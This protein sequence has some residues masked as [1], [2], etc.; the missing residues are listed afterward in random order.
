MPNNA[1][2]KLIPMTTFVIDYYS[3]EGYADLQTLKLMINYAQFLKKDLQLGMFV[4]VDQSGEPLKEPKN[5][6]SWKSIKHNTIESEDEN[7]A[8][9]EYNIY[10]KAAKKCLFEGFEVAYNG[11]SVVRIVAKYNQSIELS[12]NKKDGLCSTFT[13]VESLV[14]QDVYLSTAALKMIGIKNF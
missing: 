1:F 10:K 4:P 13:N 2:Y 12:F 11:Y 14:D 8:F 9:E 6:S 7:N 5:Y 3:N